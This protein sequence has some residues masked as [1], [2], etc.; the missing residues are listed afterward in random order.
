M[1]EFKELIKEYRDF[2]TN[3]LITESELYDNY[4]EFELSNIDKQEKNNIN[5]LIEKNIIKDIIYDFIF[6][7][8]RI[9]QDLINVH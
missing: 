6:N 8:K 9:K 4:Y 7:I 1:E 2:I 3:V 5:K